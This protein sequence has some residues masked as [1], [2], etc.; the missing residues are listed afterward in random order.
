MPTARTNYKTPFFFNK[1]MSEATFTTALVCTGVGAAAAIAR[2]CWAAKNP[3][4][5]HK[6]WL[7]P[8][9][10][11]IDICAVAA[12]Y[13]WIPTPTVLWCM[14]VSAALRAAATTQKTAQKWLL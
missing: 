11:V 1:E 2:E 8:L 5:P 13:F 14:A 3:P 9:I 6:A 12:S 7:G 4:K 10:I